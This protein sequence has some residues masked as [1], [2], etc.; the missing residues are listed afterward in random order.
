MTE[1]E[2]ATRKRG[3]QCKIGKQRAATRRA[4]TT[5]EKLAAMKQVQ[6]L[7]TAMSRLVVEHAMPDGA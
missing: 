3:L 1:Q 7:E 6:L 5:A 2:F 4:Q